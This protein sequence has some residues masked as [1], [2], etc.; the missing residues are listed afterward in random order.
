MTTRFETQAREFALKFLYQCEMEQLHFFAKAHF[1]SFVS[2]FATPEEVQDLALPLCHG[3]LNKRSEIDSLLVQASKN[4]ALDRMAVIDRT[5][6]RIAA[7]EL[8]E[9]QTPTK[10]I[11]NEAIELAK[12]Y[13]TENSSQFVNGVLDYLAKEIRKRDS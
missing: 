8:L 5:I 1:S 13:G 11:L 3:I 2:H 9:L 6:L 4:W 10:V 7:Y 12:T